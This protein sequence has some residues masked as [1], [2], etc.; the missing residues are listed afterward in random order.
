MS[1]K[2]GR[3][4]RVGTKLRITCGCPVGALINCCDN[5]GARNLSI[6]AV[7]NWPGRLNRYPKA[8]VGDM[9]LA[10]VKDG[11]PDLRKKVCAGVIV[12]Q[13]QHWRRPDGTWVYFEDNAGVIMNLKG[14][15][16]GSTISG[17]VAKEA[18][19]N[20]P[21]ISAAADSVQ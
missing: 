15:M 8:T 18:S 16:K 13:R 20:W 9:V 3:G 7:T 2:R 4:G 10:T 6:I 1:A 21:K 12:R 11:K 14:E 17:P 19:E 5:S